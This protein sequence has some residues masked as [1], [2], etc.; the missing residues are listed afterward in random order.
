MSVFPADCMSTAYTLLAES[1]MNCVTWE[2]QLC[3][4]RKTGLGVGAHWVQIL[5]LPKEPYKFESISFIS[6]SS[7][8]LIGNT[9]RKY[10]CLLSLDH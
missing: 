6:S 9:G 1:Q 3:V 7:N 10:N 8:F 4:L 5:T 2:L